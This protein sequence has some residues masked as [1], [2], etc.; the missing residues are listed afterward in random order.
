VLPAIQGNLEDIVMNRPLRH[1]AVPFAFPVLLLG[2]GGY[3]QAATLSVGTDPYSSLE[4]SESQHVERDLSTVLQEVAKA[5]SDLKVK[6][7]KTAENDLMK[8][9]TALK[10]VE[11]TYGDDT[12]MSVN[13]S[14]IHNDLNR[15][16]MDAIH[17]TD[18]RSLKEL[19]Q[20]KTWLRDGNMAS[21]SKAMDKLNYPLVFAEIDVPLGMTD[22]GLGKAIKL[23]N[24]GKLGQAD[25]VL[26]ETQYDSQTGGGIFGGKF[27]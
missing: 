5:R 6:H 10:D 18:E 9:R 4:K 20:A 19:D 17:S 24:S 25:K 15:S 11:K 13:V 26:D 21:A 1:Y 2:V 23:V 16:M 22:A 3:S 14:A 8:A 27:N 7:T 12:T